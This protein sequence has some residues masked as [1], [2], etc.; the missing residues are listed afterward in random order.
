[1]IQ[2]TGVTLPTDL[3]EHRHLADIYKKVIN[4]RLFAKS[5]QKVQ[6]NKK[7]AYDLCK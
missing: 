1:M 7:I 4:Q 2:Q 6:L 3:P 5:V